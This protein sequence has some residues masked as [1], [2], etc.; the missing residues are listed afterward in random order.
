MENAVWQLMCVVYTKSVLFMQGVFYSLSYCDIKEELRMIGGEI[1]EQR[2]KTTG[3]TLRK[4]P[5]C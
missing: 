2:Q 1:D 4:L 5:L 3:S